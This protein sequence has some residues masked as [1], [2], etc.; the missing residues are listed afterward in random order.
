[1]NKSFGFSLLEILIALLILCVGLL[2]FIK[3]EVLALQH[4]E[5][6]YFQSIAATQLNSMAER[7]YSCKDSSCLA[8]ATD[9]WKAENKKLFPRAQSEVIKNNDNYSLSIHWQAPIA[10]GNAVSIISL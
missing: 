1:M 9:T 3:A 8:T 4:S 7:I 6:A 10:E 2:G 5:T